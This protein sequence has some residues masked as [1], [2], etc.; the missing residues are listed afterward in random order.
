MSRFVVW[1]IL[2]PYLIDIRK[3]SEDEAYGAIR[4]WLD[5]CS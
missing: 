2:T 3:Y 5:E 1:R 4:N